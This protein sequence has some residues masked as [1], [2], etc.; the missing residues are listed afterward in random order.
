MTMVIKNIIMNGGFKNGGFNF[1]AKLRRQSID[2]ED[3]FIAHIGGIDILAKS[4]MNAA[5]M[6]EE[7]VLESFKKKRYEGWS[8][9]ESKQILSG[10][11]TLEQITEK[12]I[13]PEIKSGKQELLEKY[14]SNN[15]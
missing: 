12:I 15:T 7:N 13:E 6:I 5:K 14:I 9:E 10:K 1:D 3:L 4:L 8:S 11:L 2:L